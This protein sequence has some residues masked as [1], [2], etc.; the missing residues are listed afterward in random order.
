MKADAF[1]PALAVSA[2]RKALDGRPKAALHDPPA[3]GY[4]DGERLGDSLRFAPVGYSYVG[5]FESRIE[6][7]VGR[8]HA[9]AIS[10][11]TAALHLALLSVGVKPGDLVKVPALTFAGAVAAVRYCGALP[12]FYERRAREPS[13]VMRQVVLTVDLLGIPWNVAAY[14]DEPIIEDAAQALGSGNSFGNCGALGD[15]SILS[16]NSNKIVTTGGGGMVLTNSDAIAERI[17]FLATTAKTPSPHHYVHTEVGFNYRMPN[18]CAALGLV[19][20]DKLDDTLAKK[21]RLHE[22]YRAAFAD[23]P[24]VTVIEAPAG[25]TWNHWLNAIEVPAGQRDLTLQ[26]LTAAG[27]ECRALYTPLPWLEPY[28]RFAEGQTFPEAERRFAVTVCLPSGP[29]LAA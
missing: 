3:L 2:V 24:G 7:L 13:D 29:D 22:A 1:E 6:Q 14:G 15:V 25:V 27:Y 4:S 11:G 23:V 8:K 20:L 18:A 16:F 10:S 12:F 5:E 21:A 26:A 19:M 9:I 28:K 17:R